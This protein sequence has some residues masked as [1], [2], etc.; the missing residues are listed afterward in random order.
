MQGEVKSPED[1]L[2][3]HFARNMVKYSQTQSV[4][5]TNQTLNLEGNEMFLTWNPTYWLFAA[6]ALILA[7]S[8]SEKVCSYRQACSL[9]Q[10]LAALLLE[11]SVIGRLDSVNRTGQIG[12]YLLF[13]HAPDLFDGVELR[14]VLG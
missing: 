5:Q 1:L 12:S 4:V 14:S 3:K 13:H 2:H 7:L 10:V 11:E 6:P 8:R 9:K